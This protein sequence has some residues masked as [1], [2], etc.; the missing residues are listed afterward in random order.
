VTDLS[1]V[2]DVADTRPHVGEQAVAPVG[3]L[4][5]TEYSYWHRSGARIVEA[6]RQPFGLGGLFIGKGEVVFPA[7]LGKVEAYCS[8]KRIYSDPIAG[9]VSKACF[10]DTNR[11]GVFD[12]VQV[13][14]EQS[15]W[16]E[17]PLSP[18]LRYMKMDIPMPHR[19]SFKYEIAYDGYSDR[20]LHLSY[21][22]FKGKS[23]DRPAYTQQ[24]KYEIAGFPAVITFRN[25]KIE[26]AQANNEQMSYKVLRGF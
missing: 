1:A 17:R 11:D 18:A 14:P 25:V 5:F 16:V 20:T 4:V 26:V 21:R 15:N 12:T 19:G 9:F 8:D 2:S 7:R 23:L 10:S 3:G 22:E 24:A 6:N 13:A